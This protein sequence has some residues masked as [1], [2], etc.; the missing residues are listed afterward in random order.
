MSYLVLAYPNLDQRDYS[1]IQQ[2]RKQY[3]VRYFDLVKPHFTIVF[4]VD[5]IE[6]S[7]LIKHV[8][9]TV[10]NTRQ[11][12][13]SLRYTV[14]VK[15]SFSDYTDVFL[16]PDRGNSDII[17]LHDKLY[18]GIL[19]DKLIFDIPFIP[20][21]GIGSSLNQTDSKKISEQINGERFSV[22]GR[23]TTLDVTKFEE[24]KIES[25]KKIRL[26]G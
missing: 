12:S 21:L 23:I 24:T 13:F 11:I 2:I 14:A 7:A 22:N 15:D 19:E 1:W 3:D 18:T 10:K 17:R 4:K 25:I 16:I 8:E 20:H 9:D 5:D 6:E 26:Q